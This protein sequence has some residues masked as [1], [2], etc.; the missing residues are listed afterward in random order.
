MDQSP[1]SPAAISSGNGIMP[2]RGLQ[3]WGWV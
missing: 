1:L 3:A 2:P